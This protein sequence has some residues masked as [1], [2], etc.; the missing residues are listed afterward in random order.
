MQY[1]KQKIVVVGN[2]MVGHSFIE[3]LVKSEARQNYEIIV[4]GEEPR[5][6]YD[7]VYLSSYF[8][9]KTAD[10]LSLVTPGFY[11]ENNIDIRLNRKVVSIDREAKTVTVDDGS[12]QDY[13]RLVLATGSIRLCRQFRATTATV[14]WCIVL[15]KI[16]MRF[17]R[18]RTKAKSVPLSVAVYWVW[19]RRKH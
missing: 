4:F 19:K 16:W 3:K 14:V 11:E 10:D 6:A 12:V 15:S 2:G 18:R 5:K 8:S 1:T 7:R 9:G 17:K 13:D